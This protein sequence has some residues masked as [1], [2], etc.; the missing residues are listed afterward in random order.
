MSADGSYCVIGKFN[1]YFLIIPSMLL[2]LQKL[3]SVIS[4][5]LFKE[6]VGTHNNGIAP[7]HYGAT[8]TSGKNAKATQETEI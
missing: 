8:Q 3:M 1:S 6:V 7:S 2:F 4:A 5:V